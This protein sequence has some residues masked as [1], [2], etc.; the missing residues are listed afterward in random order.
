MATPATY[1]SRM[2]N[3]LAPGGAEVE[4]DHVVAIPVLLGDAGRHLDRHAEAEL[5]RIGLDVDQVAAH[6]HALGQV[7]DADHVRH[8]HPGH[9]LVHDRPYPDRPLAGQRDLLERPLGGAPGAGAS[10]PQVDRPARLAAL[11]DQVGLALVGQTKE[12]DDRAAAARRGGRGSAHAVRV[13]PP[14]APCPAL[15]T[16]RGAEYAWRPWTP[17]RDGS[18]SSPAAA[19]GSAPRWRAPSPRAARASCSP[20]SIGRRWKR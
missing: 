15:V 8:R 3:L 14:G 2:V 17:S 11:A 12:G 10:R 6:R 13:A 19:A 20:T 7:D 16:G 1:T 18:P 9:R 4:G 5:R